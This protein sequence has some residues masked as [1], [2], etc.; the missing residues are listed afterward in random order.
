M[1]SILILGMLIALTMH[2]LSAQKKYE[3]RTGK[4][5]FESHTAVE[6]FYAE[7]NQVAS[8]LK[9]NGTTK[10]VA[11]NVMMRSF[12]FQ[13]A[14]MEE[15][16][17]EKYVHSEKFPSAKFA[18]EIVDDI[19]LSKPAV[20]KNVNIKGTIILHGITRPINIIATLEVKSDSEIKGSSSFRINPKD[21]EV[22]IPSLIDE[23][24]AKEILVSVD[25]LYKS[26]I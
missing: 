19:D 14:L 13:K 17:N 12:K 1:R 5:I 2:S 23:K 11:F 10:T 24:V 25:V 7:N 26:S 4:V 21:F 3:T 6:Q 9:V 15:H 16:F 22:E 20:Y 8:I 18:G